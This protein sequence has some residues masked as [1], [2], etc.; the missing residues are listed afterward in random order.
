MRFRLG[1]LALSVVCGSACSMLST[2]VSAQLGD[3]STSRSIARDAPPQTGARPLPPLSKTQHLLYIALFSNSIEVYALGG[4]HAKLLG[5]LTKGIHGPGNLCLSRDGT[6]YV[7]NGDDGTVAVYPFGRSSPSEV[8]TA[9]RGGSPAGCAVDADGNLWVA[10]WHNLDVFEL[11]NGKN[12]IGSVIYGV[13]CADSVA[14]DANGNMYVGSKGIKLPPFF[15]C[16]PAGIEVFAPGKTGPFE[17]ITSGLAEGWL[18]D[19]AIGPD[20]TLYAADALHN[21]IVLYP[22][23]KSAYSEKLDAPT[24]GGIIDVLTVAASGRLYA[25]YN[26]DT[27]KHD[28]DSYNV[29]EFAPG[30][31]SPGPLQIGAAG[32]YALATGLAVW[33]PA[34][35]H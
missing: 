26:S 11:L 7:P 8:L 24:Q 30:A 9:D 33:P 19:I 13:V 6:L 21:D 18:Q 16:P 17:T 5:A 35:P 15:D 12:R 4:N 3:A 1:L 27:G 2:P 31:T 25:G 29:I 14:F 28:H 32:K 34:N 23:G 22:P 10:D 20:G